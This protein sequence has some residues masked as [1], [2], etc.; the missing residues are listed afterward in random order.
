MLVTRE[1]HR[2]YRNEQGKTIYPAHYFRRRQMRRRC[3]FPSDPMYYLY[4]GRGIFVCKEWLT[5]KTFQAWCLRT[6][7]EGCSL[8][9][10]DND[11]LYA[12]WN[13]RWAT[14]AEQQR[15][16]R[17]TP[18]RRA[19]MKIAIEAR[20]EMLRKLRERPTKVCPC[21]KRDLPKD[22]FNKRSARPS[23][24]QSRCK[25]CFNASYAR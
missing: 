12:P 3:Y 10:I 19:G 4:G 11:A 5:F 9:R 13:C 15:N 20:L 22:K 1:V 24:L 17:I 7:K 21:C 16:S 8:D 2:T 6:Y 18:E 23:G 25:E 14:P